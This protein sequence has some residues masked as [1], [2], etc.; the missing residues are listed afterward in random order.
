MIHSEAPVDG[1]PGRHFRVGLVVPSSNVT[2]LGL[3]IDLPGAGRLLTRDMR[4]P[5]PAE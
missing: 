5:A 3:P 1:R 2:R 4:M